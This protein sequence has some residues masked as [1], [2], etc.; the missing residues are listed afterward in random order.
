M[1]GGIFAKGRALTLS[2]MEQAVL[3]QLEMLLRQNRSVDDAVG[4]LARMG[5]D[6][7]LLSRI[8][9]YRTDLASAQ[10]SRIV[11]DGRA[12]FDPELVGAPWYTGSSENDVFWPRLRDTLMTSEGWAG[13]VPSLDESSHDIVSLL[14]NPHLPQINTRGLVVGHVQS[15]KTASFTATIA[16]AADAGYRMFIVLSGVHNALRRQTQVRLDRQLHDLEPT[17]WLTLTSVER[18]FGNPVKALA[19]MAGS[20]LRLLAVVKKNAS[21]LRRLRDWLRAAERG[22]GFDTCPVLIID[23]ESDQATPNAA[24]NADLDRT[25]INELIVEILDLPRVAYV[26]Y[27]ATPFANVLVNPADCADV[28]PRHFIYALKKA[29]EYFGPEELFG[30]DRS[31]DE[32]VADHDMIRL[33]PEEEADQH[34]VRSGQPFSAL[35]TPELARSIRWFVL[36]TA[37]RRARSGS[38]DHSSMLIHTTQRVVPQFG[39]LKPVKDYLRNIEAELLASTALLQAQWEQESVAEPAELHGLRPIAFDELL[40][41]LKGVLADTQVVV[42]NGSSLE[43]LLYDDEAATTV[44]AIGGNT[45]SRGLTLEGLTSSYFLRGA[46]TYDTLLQMGRWFGYRPGYGDLPRIWTTAELADGFR[47]LAQVERDIRLDID[48]YATELATPEDVPVRI[49][50]HPKMRVTG[51][52]RMQF[53]VPASL[54]FS[55]Q[56]PQTIKFRHRDQTVVSENLEATRAVIVKAIEDGSVPEFLGEKVILRDVAVG[57]VLWYL[58]KYHFH[59]DSEMTSELVTQYVNNQVSHGQLRTWNV[60]VVTRG[61]PV[62]GQID[63][64]LGGPVNLIERSKFRDSSTPLDADIGTLMS[65]PD[66]VAD[67]MEARDAASM[68]D[69]ALVARRTESGRALLILYPIAADSQPRSPNSGARKLREP[70]GAVDDLI[71]LALAFPRA[72][73]QTDPTSTVAVDLSR[74]PRLDPEEPEEADVEYTDIEGDQ[75]DVDFGD[76]G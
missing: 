2:E 71:G 34:R 23:D 44:I 36:A 24:R 5:I 56:R 46:G 55:G 3:E 61:K 48:R 40:P 28:Y 53:A 63:L 38:A 32:G 4:Q 68:H 69:H 58:S 16:K 49:R 26:G 70:L 14:Q 62:R 50:L 57:H 30:L 31:E 37:A 7:S 27:T 76:D 74:L 21:R 42:D 72:P 29:P 10:R 9:T 51:P 19:P 18:D 33:V 75:N 41:Q 64:G 52:L 54:S 1:A 67:I 20:Q 13:A 43:R 35:V 15:G 45:L 6:T 25:R 60:A 11:T 39:Y 66:R 59:P 73:H 12:L 8:V 22:G 17:R 47:F 65:K